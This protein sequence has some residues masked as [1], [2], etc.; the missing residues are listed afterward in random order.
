[1][2]NRSPPV[3]RK[4]RTK[5]EMEIDKFFIEKV[6]EYNRDGLNGRSFK[7]QSESYKKGFYDRYEQGVNS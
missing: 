3:K 5:K 4:R 7:E 6:K 2:G 1:M